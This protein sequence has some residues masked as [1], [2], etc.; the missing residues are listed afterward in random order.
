MVGKAKYDPNDLLDTS[1]V[2]EY[3]DVSR[4]YLDRHFPDLPWSTGG[5]RGKKRRILFRLL[6][7]YL[8]ERAVGASK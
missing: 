5:G 6:V 8:E 1:A 7:D 3:L 4:R 2:C